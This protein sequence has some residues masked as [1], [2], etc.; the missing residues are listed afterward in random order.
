MRP[1]YLP[2]TATVSPRFNSPLFDVAGKVARSYNAA[3]YAGSAALRNRVAD[4]L[5]MSEAARKV[6]RSYNVADYAGSAALRNRVADVAAMSDLAAKVGSRHKVADVLATTDLAA[7]VA[8]S[9]RVSDYAGSA[10]LRQRVPE[11]L[12][13]TDLASKVARSYRVSDYAGSAALRHRVADVLATTDLASKV[14]RSYNLA[15]YAQLR[16]QVADVR[17]SSDLADKLSRIS[18]VRLPRRDETF[19]NLIRVVSLAAAYAQPRTEP[20]AA[21]D[22]QPTTV[23]RWLRTLPPKAQRRVFLAALDA[24]SLLL[25]WAGAE[26][27]IEQPAHLDLLAA[28][29]VHVLTVLN[30]ALSTRPPD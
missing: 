9:Y 21:V 3:D 15:D 10:A 19:E 27:R 1:A 7:K 24:L 13:T 30:E 12:A 6:A 8:R 20:S 4:V 14:A 26:A 28:A 11:V 18:S 22:P 17:A 29:L 16:M 25:I 5:A 23:E 2:I